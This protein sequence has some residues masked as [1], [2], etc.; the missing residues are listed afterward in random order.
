MN[1]H[2]SETNANPAE[3]SPIGGPTKTFCD[4]I[5]NILHLE[6][7]TKHQ[8]IVVFNNKNAKLVSQSAA[9]FESVFIDSITGKH[10][11]LMSKNM[12]NLIRLTQTILSSHYSTS[13]ESTN[14]NTTGNAAG[15]SVNSTN[16]SNL[17]IGSTTSNGVIASSV[18]PTNTTG[19]I[20]HVNIHTLLNSNLDLKSYLNLV[21]KV[22]AQNIFNSLDVLYFLRVDS[23]MKWDSLKPTRL[24]QDNQREDDLKRFRE[25]SSCLIKAKLLDENQKANSSQKSSLVG[26]LTAS[27]NSNPNTRTNYPGGIY[28]R[29]EFEWKLRQ[30]T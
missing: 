22:D 27:F 17:P 4:Q 18:A 19:Q 8:N 9:E 30:N 11:T 1:G 16:I 23:K 2:P 28:C 15:V 5:E 3:T 13:Q 20:S 21:S 29:V 14:A 10:I 7:Q 12:L 6:Y 24:N 26:A 25:I